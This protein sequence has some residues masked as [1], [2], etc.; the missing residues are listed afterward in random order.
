MF[1]RRSLFGRF[2]KNRSGAALV[3]VSLTM[4]VMLALVALAVDFGHVYLTRNRLQV[5]ADAAALAG[6]SQ[7]PDPATVLSEARAFAVA[8]IPDVGGTSVLAD[9]DVTIGHWDGSAFTAGGTPQNAVRVVTRRAAA[10]G[11]ALPTTFGVL[12]GTNAFNLARTAVAINGGGSQQACILAL[13]TDPTVIGIDFIGNPTVELSECVAASNSPGPQSIRVG[14]SAAVTAP[15]I[16]SVGQADVDDGLVLTDCTDPTDNQSP[17][18]DPYAGLPEP[19]IPSTCSPA[20]P[21]GPPHASVTLNPGRFCGGFALKGQVTLNPGI[22]VIDGGDFTIDA[23]SRVFGEDVMFFL[24]NNARVHFNG[25]S[26]INLSAPDD[27]A[28]ASLDPYTG[29]LF[30]F[31]PDN[32]EGTPS[33]FNG[34]ATSQMTGVVYSPSQRMTFAGNF[35]TDQCLQIVALSLTMTGTTD[36]TNTDCASSGLAGIPTSNSLRLVL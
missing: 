10:N 5:A 2:G 29:I 21:N 8:N 20:P 4:P 36:F 34:T 24:T 25:T 32:A 35:S 3:Y 6:A 19:P 9:A 22:Y 17:I 16:V 7:L 23:T 26:T 28:P 27:L 18:A 15:C 1:L 14:G 30:F 33:I 13:D 12:M 31:D 11:N